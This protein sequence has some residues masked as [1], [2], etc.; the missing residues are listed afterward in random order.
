[1]TR[2]EIV[3]LMDQLKTVFDVVR[4]VDADV[5]A[6]ITFDEEGNPVSAPD[7]C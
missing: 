6:Q 7:Q 4:L 5:T 1:M 3:V 2:K